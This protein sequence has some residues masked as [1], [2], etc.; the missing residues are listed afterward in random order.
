MPSELWVIL[1]KALNKYN[2]SFEKKLLRSFLF[3]KNNIAILVDYDICNS[4]YPFSYTEY[5]KEQNL[6]MSQYK[7]TFRFIVDSIEDIA[8]LDKDIS[9]YL[10]K[11]FGEDKIKSSGANRELQEVDPTIPEAYFEQAFIETYG[12]ESLDKIEREF[13]VIDVNGQTRWIDYVVR[14][15]DHNIAIEKN[16]ETYHHPIITKRKGYQKQLIKQNSLVAYGYKVFRWSLEGMKFKETFREELKTFLGNADDFKKSE[17]LSLT[18]KVILLNH[19]SDTLKSINEQR[20]KGEK[21][22]LV[23]LPTG[24]G[25]T[26]IMVTDIIHQLK[27]NNNLSV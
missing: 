15:K 2:F 20:D 22:F 23:V 26:E 25:K 7:S 4:N 9:K 18:R 21:S 6:I 17:K 24:T 8:I 12:R 11:S 10:D 3:V 14:H 13:P 19:Q 1:E 16:G 5:T 27:Y